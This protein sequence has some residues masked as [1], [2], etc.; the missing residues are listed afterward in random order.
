VDSRTLNP[1]TEQVE[2]ALTESTKAVLP[3]HYGGLP[4]EIAEIAELCRSRGI[5]LVEDAACAV[6][7]RRDGTACGAFGD[8]GSWSFDA[9]K[10]LVM[11]DGGILYVRDPDLAARARTTGYLG[12][13]TASGFSAAANAAR[14]WE[15]EI[16]SFSRRSIINDVMAATGLVQLRKLPR[17]IERRRQVHEAYS[18]ELAGRDWLALP[19]DPPAGVESSYYFYW[20]QLEPDLRDGLARHLRERGIYTTFRY[21]PLHRVALYGALDANLPEAEAATARTLCLPIHQGLSDED[22]A[23]V[24][25]GVRSFG[26]SVG[27]AA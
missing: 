4:G 2:A 9:M 21:W 19:P 5:A 26:Q 12:L 17:F 14:W 20:V 24:V 8:F 6:A 16:S 11:G 25:E 13:E 15:F 27:L 23:T 3:L 18:R 10:I 1:R 7:S 22:V